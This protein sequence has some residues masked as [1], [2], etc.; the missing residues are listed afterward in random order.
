[1]QSNQA[2]TGESLQEKMVRRNIYL[3]RKY[4]QD[5]KNDDQPSSSSRPTQSP[6][7]FQVRIVRTRQVPVPFKSPSS[8]EKVTN[9]LNRLVD[10]LLPYGPMHVPQ[11]PAL[12][13]QEQ[14][15]L[16]LQITTASRSQQIENDRYYLSDDKSS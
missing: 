8:E 15:Q 10:P 13:Q 12:N 6:A 4:H 1:M 2:R 14:H 5:I 3:L 16:Q 7:S 11:H 9:Y